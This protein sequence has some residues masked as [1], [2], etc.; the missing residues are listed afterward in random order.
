MDAAGL[1]QGD[2]PPYVGVSSTQTT[3]LV[4]SWAGLSF[5]EHQAITLARVPKKNFE[6]C[7]KQNS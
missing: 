7:I 6:N 2:V 1:F 3:T 5:P 4:M